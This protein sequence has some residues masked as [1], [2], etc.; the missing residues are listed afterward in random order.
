MIM[1]KF[2]VIENNN[3]DD[4]LTSDEAKLAMRYYFNVEKMDRFDYE[5]GKRADEKL[6]EHMKKFNEMILE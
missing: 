1:N 5:K 4:T 6:V 2:E 3:P